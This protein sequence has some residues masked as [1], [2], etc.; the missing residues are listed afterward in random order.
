MPQTILGIDIGSYSVKIAEIERTFKGFELV[1]FYEHPLIQDEALAHEQIVMRTLQVVVDEYSLR[2]DIVYSALPGFDT[3]IR[4]IELPF[5]NAKKI[6]STIEFE[7][8]SYV[9]LSLEEIAVD[10]HIVSSTKTHSRILIAYAKKSAL[11]KFLSIFTDSTIEPRFVGCEPIEIGNLIQLGLPTPEEAYAIVDIGHQK[12][13]V[14]IFVGKNLQYARTIPIGG[15]HLT[16]AIEDVLKVPRSE[17]EKLKIEIGQVGGQVDSMD[18]MTRS[19]AT[20]L[21]KVLDDLCIEIK[22]TMLSFQEKNSEVPQALFLCGGTSR[23]NGID[24]YLSAQLRKNIS[25]LDAL[26]F[27]FNR[28]AES[29][30]CR[31]IIPNAL[32]LAYRGVS[33]KYLPDIQFRRGDFAYQGDVDELTQI[34]KEVGIVG[35]V[36]IGVVI[37]TLGLNYFML[38]GKVDKIG[39]RVASVASEVLPGT[40]KNTL[41]SPS[42]V[43]SMLSGRILTLKEKKGQIEE[44]TNILVL[45]VI[46]TISE[47]V[48]PKD[49]ISMDV[50]EVNIAGTRLNVKG[51]TKSFEE[52]DRIK[53]AMMNSKLFKDVSSGNIRKGVQDE[54]K[55]DLSMEIQVSGSEGADGT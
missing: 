21:Q 42:S 40:S 35:V 4:E 16:E 17:A 48:P 15:A 51:R 10:Y 52:V 47:I 54:V 18:D 27:A 55:F 22:Q 32:A 50:E 33:S 46:K 24:V 43:I 9:P 8:E 41:S 20:A 38:S 14:S 29:D 26:D 1:G 7:I 30:W 45:D 37:A 19:I 25:Y 34:G 6:D 11:V 3:A 39:K 23:L 31:P 49:Q 12:T 28:L 44:Q 53:T 13:N 5:T 36:T 2:P